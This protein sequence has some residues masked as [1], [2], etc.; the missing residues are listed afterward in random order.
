MEL[1]SN[2]RLL[3]LSRSTLLFLLLIGIGIPTSL[4]KAEDMVEPEIKPASA[5]DSSAFEGMSL[6]SLSANELEV[7]V[8]APIAVRFDATAP[9]TITLINRDTVPANNIELRMPIPGGTEYV[10]LPPGASEDGSDLVWDIAQLMPDYGIQFFVELIESESGLPALSDPHSGWRVDRNR[11]P[12]HLRSEPGKTRAASKNLMDRSGPVIKNEDAHSAAESGLGTESEA[13][14]DIIGGTPVPPGEAPWQVAMIFSSAAE[15]MYGFFCGGSLIA[16]QWVLTA[17]HCL[18]EPGTGRLREASEIEVYAGSQLLSAGGTRLAVDEI[19][20]NAEYLLGFLSDMA[21]VH[22]TD[23]VP[24]GVDVTPANLI[25]QGEVLEAAEGQ[26]VRPS[27]WGLVQQDPNVISDPLLKVDLSRTELAPCSN[28]TD[29]G[30]LFCADPLPAGGTA[31]FGDSGG[32]VSAVDPNSSERM[33]IGL[34][35][36]G[37]ETSC[38]HPN[39]LNLYV[40]L[41]LYR[42]WI[43]DKMQRMTQ[44]QIFVVDGVSASSGGG[45]TG[46]QAQ[47]ANTILANPGSTL[48]QVD[49]I[50]W[51]I[52]GDTN[53]DETINVVDALGVLRF[54]AGIISSAEECEIPDTIFLPACDT[55]GDEACN[56]VDAL[57]ILQCDAGIANQLCPAE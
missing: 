53:C 57:L 54:D 33:Q 38:T 44:D 37:T 45:Q 36:G 39:I 9:Y 2:A 8:W 13:R 41:S 34:V 3:R 12:R 48:L 18:V 20:F 24:A 1:G 22:L 19:Y 7:H 14:P 27:G 31:C 4:T 51:W 17:A 56:V 50:P 5:L 23:P 42:H 47:P 10:D 30:R 43:D 49:P 29:N 28:Y 46:E 21:L 11:L 25:G 15:P 16:D 35:H 26:S 40:D 52:Q 55:N 6:D 32:P